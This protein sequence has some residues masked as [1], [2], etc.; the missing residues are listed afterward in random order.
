MA[1]ILLVED[2][3][4]S[5]DMLTRRLVVR[6][7]EVETAVNG[8]EAVRL[9]VELQPDLILMDLSLPVLDGFE[10]TQ[11][12]KADASTSAIP[13]IALTAHVFSD[14]K[15]RAFK[16]GCSDYET[17]PIEFDRLLGKMNALMSE[18]FRNLGVK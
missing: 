3:E 9:A 1:R 16:A 2:N 12:I 5:R 10:A 15:A 4:M 6:G 11:A 17:K 8:K 14:D 13:I 7:F 18:T